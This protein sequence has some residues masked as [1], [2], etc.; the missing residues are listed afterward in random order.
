QWL[1]VQ[2]H[3]DDALARRLTGDPEARGK[4]ECWFVR[5]A[6]PGAE[7]IHGLRAGVEELRP[8]AGLVRQVERRNVESGDVFLTPAGTV[9]AL[10]PGL[11]LYEIQQS[12]DLTYRLYDWDRPGLDG[13]P[14]PLHWEQSLT[15]LREVHPRAEPPPPVGV[16]G[17]L[18]VN[19]P[20]FLV[21][22]LHGWHGWTLDGTSFEVLTA[23]SGNATVRW[24]G[25][26]EVLSEGQAVIL[27]AAL[28][29]EV[30]AHSQDRLLRTRLPGGGPSPPKPTSG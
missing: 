2:V 5:W 25:G 29:G 6:A 1:S 11:V 18:R 16:I 12:S 19:T 28:P 22:E 4:T 10:G 17:R 27:P 26:A 3:P 20:F 23:F 21:E 13:K 9:H 24:N 8:D 7:I 30:E 14:R 15:V